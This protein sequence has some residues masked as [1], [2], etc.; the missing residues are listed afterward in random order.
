VRPTGRVIDATTPLLPVAELAQGRGIRGILARVI[1]QT[2]EA[3]RPMAELP[4]LLAKVAALLPAGSSPEQA[5]Q[6]LA[7]AARR[8]LQTVEAQRKAL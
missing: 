7:T 8:L 3:D 1:Q 2:A 5:R 6:T 4:D